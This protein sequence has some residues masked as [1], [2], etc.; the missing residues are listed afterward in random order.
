MNAY[1]RR[2]VSTSNAG[3]IHR[4]RAHVEPLK[5][6]VLCASI[7]AV[8]GGGGAALAQEA[9]EEIVITGS[10]IV[11]RD[12]DAPSP[13]LTVDT[14]AFEQIEQRLARVRAEP[15][16][17]VQGRRHAVRRERHPADGE[18]LA[19]HVDAEPARPRREPQLG[20]AR[21]PP[22]PASQRSLTVDVTRCPRPRS[23]SVEVISG[24]AAATYGPDA[25]AGV[26]NFIL[27]A[28]SRA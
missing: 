1:G 9:T 20:A 23:Q 7:C 22:R 8:L 13:I 5:L 16:P 25:M 26:V 21:R 4:A 15:V 3:Y 17:A 6:T 2:S 11:R 27:K 14:E 28:I 19:R 18:Q 24:G 12:L 10:R